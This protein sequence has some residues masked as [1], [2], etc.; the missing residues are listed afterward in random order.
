MTTL[1]KLLMSA[2]TTMASTVSVDCGQYVETVE[3]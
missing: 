1:F 2:L 3:G